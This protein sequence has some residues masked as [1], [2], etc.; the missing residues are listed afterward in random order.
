[1]FERTDS[2][3]FLI[4]RNRF[5][6]PQ[7]CQ[8][9]RKRKVRGILKSVT[10][11]PSNSAPPASSSGKG[12][13]T[14]PNDG[15]TPA[16]NTGQTPAPS[17]VEDAAQTL[18]EVGALSWQLFAGTLFAI[19]AYLGELLDLFGRAVK[20][21]IARGVNGGDLARQMSVIG[22]DTVPI[23]VM[24]VGFSGAVLAL[25]TVNTLR[26]YGVSDLVGGIVALS[27]V[28]ETGPI[29]A[30]VVV[31]ARAGS[32]M[33]AEIAS[34][35]VS[36]QVDALRSMAISPEEY[37]VVPRVLGC[38][39]VV[40]LLTMLANAGGVFGGGIVAVLKGVSW[41]AYTASIR[42][43][44]EPDGSDITKG[45]LKSVL[46]G[47]IVALIGCREGLAT[48]GGAVGVGQSTTRSVVISIVL[49]FVANFLL[50]FLL[51]N[52]GVS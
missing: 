29:L 20:S 24:T 34:M 32:A 51:F 22:V 23:A 18:E 6:K 30:G 37:L 42:Q 44:L 2:F 15:R 28:R 43:L 41:S 10:T 4:L 26:T 40:P 13:G 7:T 11:T 47:L 3:H 39:I 14:P 33:T 36:E 27:I 5:P 46:F 50:S 31:A 19:F 21:A 16:S 48:E 38:L 25:Y 52:R 17:P 12:P 9:A 49:V 8:L 35:K 45:L 1:M